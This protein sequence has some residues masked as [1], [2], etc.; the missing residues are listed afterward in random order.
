MNKALFEV[1]SGWALWFVAMM[2]CV[3]KTHSIV[4][5]IEVVVT[6]VKNVGPIIE[7]TENGIII[8]DDM[9][10]P[11]VLTGQAGRYLR[12]DGDVLYF[13]ERERPVL[14]KIDI[15]NHA[16]SAGSVVSLAP[17]E[18]PCVS[19]AD[20]LVFLQRQEDLSVDA[21][22]LCA[23][24]SDRSNDPRVTYNLRIDLVTG[25]SVRRLIQAHCDKHGE[26]GEREKIQPRLC[27]PKGPAGDGLHVQV[28]FRHVVRLPPYH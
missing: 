5:D 23:E 28:G 10:L 22:V 12:L 4:P 16:G 15:R 6:P 1:S 19:A 13:F 25:T 20:P 9:P 17:I 18:G 21:G 26:N 8:S 24:L 3:E 7:S 2:G 27:V 11:I 14:R